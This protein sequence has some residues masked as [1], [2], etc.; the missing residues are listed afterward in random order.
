MKWKKD[1]VDYLSQETNYRR[2]SILDVLNSWEGNI[3][4]ED[5]EPEI[6]YP[7]ENVNRK[8]PDGWCVAK[9]DAIIEDFNKFFNF[10]F[11]VSNYY[12]INKTITLTSKTSFG[13]LITRDEYLE[14]TGRN[15]VERDWTGVRFIGE[16][17]DKYTFEKIGNDYTW[18]N[19]IHNF[20]AEFI[21]NQFIDGTWTEIK[22][23]P[24][25]IHVQHPNT[26]EKRIVALEKQ[27]E[28]YQQMIA[29]WDETLAGLQLL[30]S[31]NNKQ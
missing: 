9:C 28:K 26:L 11:N 5:E 19:K 29:K 23:E 22:D 13:T 31:P 24:T 10:D 7:L 15:K 8:Y 3:P 16:D 21:T 20:D 12:G 17:G 6:V 18:G 30:L 25:T 4:F 1:F 27:D 2:D 14:L